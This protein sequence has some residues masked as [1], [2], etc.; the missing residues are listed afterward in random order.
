MVKLKE[1]RDWIDTLPEEFLEFDLVNAEKGKLDE[2]H[3]YRLDKPVVEIT[4]D[5][6]NKEVVILNEESSW[7]KQ[8]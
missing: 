3:H 2:E 4:I 1:L 7:H 5:E 6:E 8:D